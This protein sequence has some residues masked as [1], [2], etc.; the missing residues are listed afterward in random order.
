MPSSSCAGSHSEIRDLLKTCC[1]GTNKRQHS[2]YMGSFPLVDNCFMDCLSAWFP[3]LWG[4]RCI[5]CVLPLALLGL[6]EK[7]NCPFPCWPWMSVCLFDV[8]HKV[9]LAAGITELLPA[10]ALG[11]SV[12][13]W[14]Q[15]QLQSLPEGGKSV[16]ATMACLAFCPWATEGQKQH[17]AGGSGTHL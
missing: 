7:E 12:D 11:R 15:Q 8:R 6:Q 13:P 4:Q 9:W 1:I 3:C 16:R 5:G 2:I 10:P 17:V 14:A